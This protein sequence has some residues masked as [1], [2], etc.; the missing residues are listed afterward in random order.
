VFDP[1]ARTDTVRLRFE[2]PPGGELITGFAAGPE[3]AVIDIVGAIDDRV[4]A[5]STMVDVA[6]SPVSVSLCYL[7]PLPAAAGPVHPQRRSALRRRT[8]ARLRR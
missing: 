7:G 5:P 6:G 8:A 4:P 1:Q 3:G 2:V